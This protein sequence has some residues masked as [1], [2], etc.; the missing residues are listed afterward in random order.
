[1]TTSSPSLAK[2]FHQRF[3]G[4][5]RAHGQYLMASDE[6]PAN[7][8]GKRKVKGVTRQLPVTDGLWEEHLAGQYMLG[9]VPVNDDG[10]L[11]FGAIDID[12]YP[13][14]LE[15]L[16]AKVHARKVPVIVTRTK[17]GGAHLYM[18]GREPLPA[19]IAIA[20]M[21]EWAVALGHGGV[22]V[23]PKQ[24]RLANEKDTGNW[25]N[26]P[27][28]GGATRSLRYGLD[29]N[30]KALS[31]EAFLDRALEIS[32]T[33][34]E[35]EEIEIKLAPEV[36]SNF[37]DGP[38]CLQTLAERG[39]PEGSR[40]NALFDVAVYLKKRYGDDWQQHLDK[41]NT[42]YMLPPLGH[43]EVATISK[44]VG[45]KSY[46]Y[47]CKD[48]PIAAVCNRSMCVMRKYGVEDG[49][50]TP[51]FEL[52]RLVQLQTDPVTWILDVNGRGLELTTEQLHTYRLFQQRC[53]EVLTFFPKPL[54][55][56]HWH[57]IVRAA[58][59]KA[60][61]VSVPEDATKE[62]QLWVQLR[63][64][65]TSRVQGKSLDELLL[66][67]PFTDGKRSFFQAADF[68]Q[69]LHQN[70]ISG[71]RERDIWAWLRKRKAEH[72]EKV[73][74]GSFIN[75]W[76]VPAFVGQSEDFEVPRVQPMGEM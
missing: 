12:E 54:K 1:M 8:E 39:F 9:I 66:G 76:S 13:T 53:M 48:Q 23:F 15:K 73:M 34:E 64:F 24:S 3:L 7:E 72:H 44:S 16:N 60:E 63:R 28:F 46:N 56:E 11:W 69:F 70:R 18:F 55:N 33:L 62:G 20:K 71:V 27:Y 65:C 51:D 57:P 40:N 45:K 10:N 74:K 47:K 19:D 21:K 50:D 68:I 6:G 30:N 29:Q 35:L 38:P 75:Y 2:R 22:E 61:I 25:I 32:L 31:A 49:K 59:D 4:L 17:S 52:G 26:M 58:L 67:K 37:A 36:D 5:E 42:R 14:D 41:Y 43:Q